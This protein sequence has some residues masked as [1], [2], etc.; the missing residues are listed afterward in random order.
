MFIAFEQSPFLQRWSFWYEISQY[1]TQKKYPLKVMC[2]FIICIYKNFLFHPPQDAPYQSYSIQSGTKWMVSPWFTNILSIK[3]C[4]Q[5][6]NIWIGD[7]THFRHPVALRFLI[8]QLMCTP[9]RRNWWLYFFKI[10]VTWKS[11]LQ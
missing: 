1:L 2:H 5:P 6:L 3:C 8:L 4:I 11:F 9:K 10:D 7:S